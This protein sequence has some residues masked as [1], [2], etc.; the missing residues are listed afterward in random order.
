MADDFR[1][2]GGELFVVATP[3]GNLEDITLRALRILREADGILAE[4]TRVTRVLLAKHGIDT[5]LRSLHEHNENARTD[6]VLGELTAG[7]KLALVT[8]AGT[9]AVSDPGARLIRA[10]REAGIAVTVIP[11]PS[12]VISALVT[13]GL[14]TETFQFVGFPP[15][16][17]GERAAWAKE[18]LASTLTTVFFESPHRLAATL[19]AI[20]AIDAS[21]EAAVCRELTKRFEEVRRGPIAALAAE[22]AARAQIKGEITVVLAPGEAEARPKPLLDPAAEIARLRAEGKGD[23]AI[24]KAIARATGRPRR[25]VYAELVASKERG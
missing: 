15:R 8:D 4:D 9:P 6:S 24:A 22:F 7:R 13:A 10:A 3:I 20:A 5:P 17:P 21:R 19:Q 11:G 2:S 1:S 25:E 14:S 16:R 23:A 18:R 12:A